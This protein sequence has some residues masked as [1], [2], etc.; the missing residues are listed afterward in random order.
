[1]VGKV[2]D[3][4]SGLDHTGLSGLDHTGLSSLGQIRHIYVSLSFSGVRQKQPCR[5]PKKPMK[6]RQRK[7]LTR[8]PT[9]S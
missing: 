8:H 4:G 6:T 5:S 3:G 9:G 2:G 7:P 1:M